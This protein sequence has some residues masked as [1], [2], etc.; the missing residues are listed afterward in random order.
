MHQYALL[1]IE[2]MAAF[3]IDYCSLITHSMGLEVVRVKYRVS[4]QD[5]LLQKTFPC[6]LNVESAIYLEILIFFFSDLF[7]S[8]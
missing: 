8:F 4:C 2:N 6:A 7:S 1:S 5:E 3:C